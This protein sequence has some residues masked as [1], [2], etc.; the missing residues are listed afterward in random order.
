MF[1]LDVS[2]LGPQ[3][4]VVRKSASLQ[5]KVLSLRMDKDSA[6]PVE[7]FPVKESQYSEHLWTPPMFMCL[8]F[9][10][11][12]FGLLKYVR[13]PI[14]FPPPEISCMSHYKGWMKRAQWS[15][16]IPICSR[17]N[18]CLSPPHKGFFI[19][20][21][22]EKHLTQLM[23]CSGWADAVIAQCWFWTKCLWTSRCR[24]HR[25]L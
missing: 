9:C 4:F 23:S 16:E 25:K 13:P 5:R 14:R 15:G 24:V 10:C 17:Y 1:W 12:Y 8:C 22:K 3:T 7:D 2:S 18:W 20:G 21:N 19:T 6:V 11:C